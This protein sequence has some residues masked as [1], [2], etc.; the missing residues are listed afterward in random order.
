MKLA[1]GEAPA[2]PNWYSNLTNAVGSGGKGLYDWSIGNL[3]QMIRGTGTGVLGGLGG[4]ESHLVGGLANRFGMP[5]I[6]EAAHAAGNNMLTASGHGFQDA[7]AG[8]GNIV[9]RYGP[10]GS[11][12]LNDW[13]ETQAQQFADNGQN[14]QSGL[15][16]LSNI[17]SNIATQGLVMAGI[18]AGAGATGKIGPF[19]LGAPKWLQSGAAATEPAAAGGSVVARVAGNAQPG[20]WSRLTQGW[21]ALPR[22]VKWPI[23]TTAA[24]PIWDTISSTLRGEQPQLTPEQQAN[25]TIK[26]FADPSFAQQI[27]EMYQTGNKEGMTLTLLPKMKA[28]LP[29]AEQKL[30]RPANEISE[31]LMKDGLTPEKLTYI[32]ET[33]GGREIAKQLQE[34]GDP[35]PVQ[36]ASKYIAGLPPDKQLWLMFGGLASMLGVGAMLGGSSGFWPLLM[37]LMGGGAAAYGAGAFD[38]SAPQGTGEGGGDGEIK[39]PVQPQQGQQPAQQPKLMDLVGRAGHGDLGAMDQ[40]ADQMH[41]SRWA[42]PSRW[43]NEHLGLGNDMVQQTVHDKFIEYATAQGIDPN[44]AEQQWQLSYNQQAPQQ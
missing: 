23:T 37:M 6:G 11:K 5:Q 32:M 18:G 10:S 42:G 16:S 35:N 26:S 30:G 41:A 27:N 12:P 1:A 9:T 21:N 19:A 20:A 8:A 17:G 29:Y 36:S 24:T 31:S 4:A 44:L 34:K 33:P 22:V 15:M 7:L 13:N 2:S 39:P 43:M 3:G 14:F 25:E 40:A 38:D 28:M